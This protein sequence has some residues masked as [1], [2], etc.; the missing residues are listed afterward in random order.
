MKKLKNIF[1]LLLALTITACENVDFGD[2]NRNENGPTEPYTSGLLASAIMSFATYS[3]RDGLMKPTLYV[4]Y[5]SQVTYTDEMLY[6]EVPSSW[7]TWYVRCLSP[8]QTIIDYVGDEANHKPA[9]LTQGSV[10]NQIGVA[11]IMKATVMKRVTDTYGDVPFSQALRGAGQIVPAFDSQE[12]IYKNLI[13]DLKSARNMLNGDEALPTGDILYGGEVENWKK[14]ANSVIMQMALTLSG[15]Y[16]SANDY[17][18]T[19]FK[20]ALNDPSGVIESLEDEAWFKFEDIAGFRN[21]WNSNRTPDYFLTKEFT[22]ALNG[23]AELN[24]TS[25]HTFDERLKVY[26][27][28][29]TK[30]GIPYGYDD[31][32]GAGS[33]SVSGKYYWNST[34]PLPLMTASYGYLNRADAANL[35]WTSENATEMLTQ[36]IIM[37]YRTL[38]ELTNATTSPLT[39]DETA[40]VE[41]R[42]D[43]VATVGIGQVIA[44]EKWVSLFGSAFD[45]WTEW[46]RSGFPSLQPAKDY[47]NDGKIPRRYLYPLEEVSLNGNRYDEAVAHL[48]PAVDKGTSRIWWDF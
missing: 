7:N 46:R 18:A 36:G 24:P 4:Q 29:Y 27:D 38:E 41:A 34:T 15:R 21:P 5:Q 6:A 10:N 8:L 19:E 14:L 33:S 43:D 31:G 42:L 11:I 48:A 22:D 1:S 2:I 9:L 40:Y 37:S 20:A 16:P 12:S 28:D 17:A 3:G 44:E 32:S 25:N 45:A 35:G 13:A 23:N 39:L 47:Y 30:P 26:A